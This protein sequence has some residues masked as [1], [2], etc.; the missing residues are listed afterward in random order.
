[1]SSVSPLAGDD[2]VPL[3]APAKYYMSMSDDLGFLL[4]RLSAQSVDAVQ[5]MLRPLGLSVRSYVVLRLSASD[6][7]PSQ[8]EL[9]EL[10]G[11]DPSQVVTLVHKLEAKG[12]VSRRQTAADRRTNRIVATDAGRALAKPAKVTIDAA[13]REIFAT[14][15]DEH[16]ETMRTLFLSLLTAGASRIGA[17]DDPAKQE[18]LA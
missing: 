12:L 8:R 15:P 13:L 6:A 1:M 10:L 4:A 18:S 7:P 16:L 17:A 5:E 9:A 11:L 14:V 2:V 3:S